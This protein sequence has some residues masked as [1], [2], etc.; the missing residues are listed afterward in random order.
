MAAAMAMRAAWAAKS[1]SRSPA[2]PKTTR[3]LASIRTPSCDF[4]KNMLAAVEPGRSLAG[5]G[6]LAYVLC[7]HAQPLGF[8]TQ[9]AKSRTVSSVASIPPPAPKNQSASARPR[10]MPAPSIGTSTHRMTTLTAPNHAAMVKSG[11]WSRRL[12]TSTRKKMLS[13]KG[14]SASRHAMT[15]VACTSSIGSLRTG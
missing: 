10:Q 14:R 15:F 12:C 11:T 4:S 6:S 1:S 9:R 8:A 3:G 2:Q 5:S 13:L 7:A